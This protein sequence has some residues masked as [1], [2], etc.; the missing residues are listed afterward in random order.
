MIQ[1]QFFIT[2]YNAIHGIYVIKI[3]NIK[4]KKE[5]DNIH[6]LAHYECR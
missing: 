2:P 6:T 5:N 3:K 1:I 4:A